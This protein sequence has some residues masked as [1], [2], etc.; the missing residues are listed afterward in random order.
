MRQAVRTGGGREGRAGQGKK[1]A[2]KVAG[3]H[4]YEYGRQ[5]TL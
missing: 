3:T 1:E 2:N 4:A 5:R